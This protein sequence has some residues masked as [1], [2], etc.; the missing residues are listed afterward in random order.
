MA[1]GTF[2]HGISLLLA[3]GPCHE[4]R[5]RGPMPRG[6]GHEA[7]RGTS[8]VARGTWQVALCIRSLQSPPWQRLL[9]IVADIYNLRELGLALL[10]SSWCL[11]RRSGVE[12]N[13]HVLA[14]S[15]ELRPG[16]ANFGH[17]RWRRAVFNFRVFQ[18][19][20]CAKVTSFWSLRSIYQ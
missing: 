4:A 7:A 5:C 9:D 12:T 1:S 6:N 14:T 16:S 8:Q 13:L 18:M 15:A 20:L 2:F 11:A 3:T 10:T 19:Y 17:L